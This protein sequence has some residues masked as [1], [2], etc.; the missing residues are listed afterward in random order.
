MSVRTSS[1]E[2]RVASADCV[3]KTALTSGVKHHPRILFRILS[4]SGSQLNRKAEGEQI[5]S[6]L[7]LRRPHLL[8]EGLWPPWF[9]GL[10]PPPPPSTLH[11]SPRSQRI[12]LRLNHALA[13]RDL[14]STDSRSD[15]RTS[16]SLE[17]HE[18]TAIKHL[19]WYVSIY[20]LWVLSLGR[21]L[22]GRDLYSEPFSL[23]TPLDSMLPSEGI[24]EKI[25]LILHVFSA[26]QHLTHKL[27]TLIQKK[28]KISQQ[29]SLKAISFCS[30]RPPHTVAFPGR[31]T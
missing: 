19:L 27:R 25:R 4:S 8:L 9:L 28:G 29:L 21:T 13:F 10:G 3:K 18:P 26:S 5:Y 2:I 1:E 31:K 23:E 15:C 20:T 16:Q 17:Q 24:Y 7:E 22:T 6:Q 11:P 12:W 30:S 14:Q